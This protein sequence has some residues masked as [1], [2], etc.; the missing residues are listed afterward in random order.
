M[1]H[2]FF[3]PQSKSRYKDD[4]IPVGFLSSLYSPHPHVF[5]WPTME[6]FSADSCFDKMYL[7]SSGKSTLPV[8]RVQRSESERKREDLFCVTGATCCE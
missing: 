6:Q 4:F 7:A 3:F 1:F 8:L 5:A 2:A